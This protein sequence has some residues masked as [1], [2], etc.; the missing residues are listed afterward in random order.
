M[1]LRRGRVS[2]RVEVQTRPQFRPDR[3][4]GSHRQAPDDAVQ[5]GTDVY[6]LADQM[7]QRGAKDIEASYS[8]HVV[9]FFRRVQRDW[10]QPGNAPTATGYSRDRLGLMFDSAGDFIR[11]QIVCRADYAGLIRQR[12]HGNQLA[13]RRV[14][15]D[16]SNEMGA[17]L[18]ERMADRLA[19]L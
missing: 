5:L 15:F 13:H 2:G 19:E 11:A 10:P 17:E 7:I 8:E 3:I 9:P 18:A 4:T 6:D 12:I 16:P 14:V 1:S